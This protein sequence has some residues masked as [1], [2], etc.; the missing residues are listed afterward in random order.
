MATRIAAVQPLEVD[1]PASGWKAAVYRRVRRY[2]GVP[3][4]GSCPHPHHPPGRQGSLADQAGRIAGRVAGLLEPLRLIEVDGEH[5]LA[6]LRASRRRGAATTVQY[7]EVLRHADGTTRLGRYEVSPAAGKRQA[8]PFTLTHEALA[9]V[10]SDL[11]ARLIRGD[12]L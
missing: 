9:K 11:A 12:F 4:P 6:Q 5:Q 2:P 1:H 10:V 7:Y 8:V 3:A